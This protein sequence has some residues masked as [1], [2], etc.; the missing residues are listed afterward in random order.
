MYNKLNQRVYRNII[1]WYSTKNRR[2]K[3]HFFSK[4]R[5]KKMEDL[6]NI[7]IYMLNK[8]FWHELMSEKE[9]AAWSYLDEE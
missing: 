9:D 8:N 2:A 3:Q 5:T 6:K 7:A 4:K 1:T